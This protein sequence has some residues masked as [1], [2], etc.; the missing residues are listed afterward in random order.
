MEKKGASTVL[1][2][3]IMYYIFLGIFLAGMIVALSGLRNNAVLWEEVYAKELA[4]IIDHSQSGTE[5]K[6]DV[7]R[8][9]AIALKNGRALNEAFVFDNIQNKVIV[10][11]RSSGGSSFNY[12]TNKTIVDWHT[13]RNSGGIDKDQ[14]IFTVR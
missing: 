5:V 13:E 9:V 2:E 1:N 4:R 6:L 11:L 7:T 8:G 14:L 3:E 12:L 10:H